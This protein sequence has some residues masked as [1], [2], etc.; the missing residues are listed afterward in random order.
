M[1]YWRNPMLHLHI[2]FLVATAFFVAVSTLTPAPTAAQTQDKTPFAVLAELARKKGDADLSI[3]RTCKYLDVSTASGHCRSFQ[4]AYDNIPGVIPS[5]NVV[6]ATPG[7]TVIIVVRHFK[8]D[9]KDAL[10]DTA[11]VYLTGVEAKLQK[12]IYGR[13][14]GLTKKDKIVGSGSGRPFQSPI[15]K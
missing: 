7:R 5:F 1:R 11:R 15:R 2:R 6:A 4:L 12:A 13:K 3:G 14:K 8:P 10:K 9:D